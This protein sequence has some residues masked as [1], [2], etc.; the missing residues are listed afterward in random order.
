MRKYKWG[1]ILTGL[2]LMS[3]TVSLNAADGTEKALQPQDE[4]A[5]AKAMQNLSLERDNWALSYDWG[6]REEYPQRL[7]EYNEQ[8]QSFQMEH[9]QLQLQLYSLRGDEAAAQRTALN[10]DKLINGIEGI[11]QNLP[12]NLPAAEDDSREGGTR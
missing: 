5:I 1:L 4:P 10:I 3:V 2:L 8:M 11:P 12:R 6:A 7:V 9:L